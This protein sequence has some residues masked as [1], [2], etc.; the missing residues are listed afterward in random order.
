MEGAMGPEAEPRGA[1]HVRGQWEVD[2]GRRVMAGSKGWEVGEGPHPGLQSPPTE[3]DIQPP[4]VVSAADGVNLGEATVPRAGHSAGIEG[5]C[6]KDRCHSHQGRA[7]HHTQA[8]LAHGGTEPPRL[9]ETSPGLSGVKPTPLEG[10]QVGAQERSQS[11]W[12]WT[13]RGPQL[14]AARAALSRSPWGSWSCQRRSA[15]LRA[16]VWGLH[17]S[18][19]PTQALSPA[20]LTGRPLWPLSTHSGANWQPEAAT[21]R[22]EGARPQAN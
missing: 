13:L 19:A 11:P 14:G 22:P 1:G 3:L 20:C 8:S 6:R 10:T 16:Q 4:P 12:R 17:G 21:Q 9:R 15:S 18:P 7:S 5:G 2:V